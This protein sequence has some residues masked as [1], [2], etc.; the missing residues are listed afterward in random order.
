VSRTDRQATRNRT[1]SDCP[2]FI[3]GLILRC[4]RGDEA[5]L[6]LL[7]DLF[8]A[9]VTAAVAQSGRPAPAGELVHETFVRVWRHA[10]TFVP[11]DQGPV[12]WVMQQA[13][14]A[15]QSLIVTSPAVTTAVR[16]GSSTVRVAV[17]TPG[18]G[19]R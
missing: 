13:A 12:E 10:P 5:A 18:I 3:T 9:P 11:G 2:G 1:P 14:A 19:N 6:G 15:T 17:Q 4:G 7:F 16:P 8:C